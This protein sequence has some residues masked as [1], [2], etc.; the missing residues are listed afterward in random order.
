[1]NVLLW[2]R[3]DLRIS[4]HPALAQ[5]AG[6]GP[7]LPVFIADPAEWRQADM[8][9]RH[10]AFAADCLRDL[11]EELAVLGLPL[12]LRRGAAPE[13]LASLVRA[14]DITHIVTHRSS[15]PWHL[16]QDQQLRAW[17]ETRGVIWHEVAPEADLPPMPMVRPVAEVS[18]GLLPD[19]RALGLAEMACAQRQAGG[20]GRGLVLAQS[21][22][23]KKLAGYHAAQRRGD[24]AHDPRLGA[25]LAWGSLCRADLVRLMDEAPA[26]VTPADR[27]ALLAHCAQAVVLDSDFNTCADPAFVAWSKGRT[28]WPFVDAAMRAL[29]QSG[30][31]SRPVM[32][33]VIHVALRHFAL[34]Q[35]AVLAWLAQLSTDHAPARMAA[36]LQT[37]PQPKDPIRFGETADPQGA[38]IRQWLPELATLPEGFLHRPWQWL[39]AAALAD[40]PPPQIVPQAKPVLRGRAGVKT[41]TLPC[42]QRQSSFDFL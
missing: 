2:F 23:A 39:G 29:Q 7:V 26:H 28:G 35:G 24:P 38:F 32:Q 42:D 6:L 34:P 15:D 11:K 3:R 21:F 41:P 30:H 33:H 37:G 1:M 4:D 14:Y 22:I 16:T 17:A 20:R 25:H 36:L 27:K 31:L 5:A 9:A 10:W 19:A 13:V 18:E 8:S 12:A 40:Y